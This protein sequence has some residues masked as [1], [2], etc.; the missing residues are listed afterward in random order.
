MKKI[1]VIQGQGDAYN[2]ILP[3]LIKNNVSIIKQEVL[4]LTQLNNKEYWNSLQNIDLALLDCNHWFYPED[5]FKQYA[6]KIASVNFPAICMFQKTFAYNTHFKI[7]EEFEKQLYNRSK[8][9]SDIIRSKQRKTVIVSPP[10]HIVDADTQK[11]FLDYLVYNRSLFDVYGVHCCMQVNDHSMGFIA[12]FLH[13]AL[14]ALNK[15]VWITKWAVPSREYSLDGKII[16]SK[17]D[18]NNYELGARNLKIMYQCINDVSSQTKWFFSG[19]NADIFN[20][21]KSITECVQEYTYLASAKWTNE[22]FLGLV[23]PDGAIKQAILKSL[24]EI[25]KTE[26]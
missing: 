17:T 2:L 13:Q 10:M 12:G 8:I 15:P 24:L 6:N 25:I 20:P 16:Q 1:N 3:Y 14:T 26:N 22:H 7:T 19:A 11:R 18:T 21:T 4:S 9:L 23:T 5:I